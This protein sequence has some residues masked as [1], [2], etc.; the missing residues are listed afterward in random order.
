M[1][2]RVPRAGRPR[3]LQRRADAA[4]LPRRRARDA[5]RDGH[6]LTSPDTTMP[7]LTIRNPATGDVIDERAA[8][9]AASVAAKAAAARAAQPAWA[10]TPLRERLAAIQRFRGAL[11]A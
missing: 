11:V 2:P 10:A 7:T 4:R 5:S 8:D 9:D 6:R 3:Q 1:A